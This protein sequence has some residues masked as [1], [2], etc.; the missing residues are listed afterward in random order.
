MTVRLATRA[1]VIVVER[2]VGIPYTL[3][4]VQ[5]DDDFIVLDMDDKF[6]VILG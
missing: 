1:S 6:N 4:E 2:V 5:Y 3:K